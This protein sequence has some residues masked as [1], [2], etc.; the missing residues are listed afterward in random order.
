MR[1]KGAARRGTR[2]EIM[3]SVSVMSTHHMLRVL[4][5]DIA[6]V[7]ACPKS[8]HWRKKHLAAHRARPKSTISPLVGGKNIRQRPVLGRRPRRTALGR[9]KKA[10]ILRAPHQRLGSSFCRRIA[11]HS[12]PQIYDNCDSS[13][14]IITLIVLM[15]FPD[16]QLASQPAE[17]AEHVRTTRIM[18]VIRICA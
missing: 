14:H 9:T 10:P 7:A 3:C 12:P 13:K 4:C 8:P 11:G 5:V 6:H 15:N 2:Y 18:R 1:D 16:I 17:S